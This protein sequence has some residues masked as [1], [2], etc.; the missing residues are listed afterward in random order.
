MDATARQAVRAHANR[1]YVRRKL[2]ERQLPYAIALEAV[3]QEMTG[4]VTWIWVSPA[5]VR[6]LVH[7]TLPCATCGRHH[8]QP[9]PSGSPA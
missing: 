7:G 4:D 3:V 9:V 2:S 5:L 8:D 1:A 6:H